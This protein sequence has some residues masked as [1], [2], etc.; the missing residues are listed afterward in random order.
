M[1]FETQV[2]ITDLA[3]VINQET[4]CHFKEIGFICNVCVLTAAQTFI[5]KY[6][7]SF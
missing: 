3:I 7:R 2:I 1:I 4:P 6:K 5:F